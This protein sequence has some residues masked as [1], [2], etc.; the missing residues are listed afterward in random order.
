MLTRLISTRAAVAAKRSFASTSAL[1]TRR[2]TNV[3]QQHMQLPQNIRKSHQVRHL[4]VHEFQGMKLLA[5]NGINVSR[6][7]V[8]KTPQEAQAAAEKLAKLG[9]TDFVVKAQ[10]LAGG[11]GKGHFSSGFKGGVHTVTSP[12][13]VAEIASK[14]LGSRLITKQT[15]S[16]GRPCNE[17]YITERLYLRR[18][19]YLSIM[20]ERSMQGPVIVASPHGGMNIEEVAEHNPNAILKVPVHVVDGLQE[21]QVKQI[22]KFLG[23]KGTA[24]AEAA[25]M[26]K[27][28]YAMFLKTDCTLLEINPLAETPDGKVFC[29]DSKLNFDENA[30]FRQHEV[31]ALRDPSQEDPREV[32]ASKA[33]LNYI[34]LDGNIGCL[35]NGAGL[36]MATLD[37]IK[38][39]GGSPANFLDL[40]G[41]A[42]EKQV[43]EAFNL[44][45]ADSSVK[46]ILV[47]I[48]GGIMRCDIIALGIIKAVQEVG[49]KKP[50]VIRLQ[51]TNVQAARDLIE[52]SGLRMVMAEDLD[53]AAK[54]AVK[55]A[56]IVTMAQNINVKVSF[57][58][59]L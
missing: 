15:G 26:V 44:L 40:G 39:Y 56:D 50:I 16:E 22:V 42:G 33:G 25:T 41:G 24:E 48:F 29:I 10:V 14:M 28:L 8:A 20:L 47:N 55:M 32:V 13:Q 45:N 23:F 21:E 19:T 5:E 4:N 11:R 3:P 36:A 38:L 18:E 57:E 54:K 59:P 6:G 37:I 12:E 53:D 35:V 7:Y 1:W 51:G 34:G 17:V 46:A 49:M 31:F 2:S 52:S 30:D 58:L 9:V 27:N 43:S